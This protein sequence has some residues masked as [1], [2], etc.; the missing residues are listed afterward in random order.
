[1]DGMD[2]NGHR[3]H[4]VEDASQRLSRLRDGIREASLQG[5]PVMAAKLTMAYLSAAT[6]EPESGVPDGP[7]P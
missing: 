7:H 2:D 4:E 3:G 5:D 6:E 1:M